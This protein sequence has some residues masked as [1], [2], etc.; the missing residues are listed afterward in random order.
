M[1]SLRA[2]ALLS[3]D[4]IR[5][6]LAAGAE[7][8]KEAPDNRRTALHYAAAV[9][10]ADVAI[11]LLDAGAAIATFD[12]SNRSPLALACRG[13]HAAVVSLLVARAPPKHLPILLTI[14]DD[15]AGA[16]PL[17][18]AVAGGALA[19]VA[20]LLDAGADPAVADRAGCT[21]L[22][23]AAERGD[24]PAV[25]ALLAAAAAGAAALLS[26]TDARGRTAL[27]AAAQEGHA[28]CVTA[29]LGAMDAA[30]INGADADGLSALGW[31]ATLGHAPVCEELLAAGADR[32][33]LGDELEGELDALLAEA[34]AERRA[35]AEAAAAAAAPPIDYTSQGR[36]LLGEIAKYELPPPK[37][38]PAL[39]AA[40]LLI[41]KW[42]APGRSK[43]RLAAS[44]ARGGM[45]DAVA[46]EAA[47]AF[48]RASLSD[49]LVSFGH[50]MATKVLVYA[51]PDAPTRANFAALLGELG[52]AGSWALQPAL[53]STPGASADLGAL[54]ADAAATC[55]EQHGVG[56]LAFIGMDCPELP[57][58]ALETA[59][60][61]SAEPSVAHVCPAADG[62][63][64]LL[65]LPADAPPAAAF[66]GVRWSASDTCLSQLA[67]LS[68]AGLRCVVGPTYADVDDAADLRALRQRL[69]DTP[70]DACRRTAAVL[71][72]LAAAG[73]LDE[74]T[75]EM[76]RVTIAPAGDV[77]S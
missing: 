3:P 4:A 47:A 27:L 11:L 63:Y 29:L 50:S 23:R 39:P 15:E 48:A 1:W 24:A 6:A 75:A 18:D 72:E 71:D 52:V 56:R 74:A 21:A 54:L 25:G 57:R 62:G 68:R 22:V 43:T 9:G 55:R 67:A 37:E 20:A 58:A 14:A 28:D 34:A 8:N 45:D 53:A 77:E 70:A 7:V 12:A 2:G 61:D 73:A 66:D 51:P 13:G 38:A 36:L 69:G 16:R 31:A 42:P 33:A 17:H 60:G 46:A 49:L 35:E 10:D 76:L 40:L 41:A 5:S 30:E 64:T 26:K 59:L 19:A 32:T 44:L 65:A